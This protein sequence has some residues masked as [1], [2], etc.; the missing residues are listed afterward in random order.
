RSHRKAPEHRAPARRLGP[1]QRSL[2]AAPKHRRRGETQI[3]AGDRL[4]HRAIGGKLRGAAGAAREM[5]LDFAC[6]PGV[7]LAVDQ[8]VKKNFSLV[9]SHFGGSSSAIHADRSMARARARRDITVPTG[10]SITSAIS[11]YERLLI[12]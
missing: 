10:A 6:V 5:V 12:S 9:A 8:R 1:R 11:R 4:A 3:G 2:D 7:E